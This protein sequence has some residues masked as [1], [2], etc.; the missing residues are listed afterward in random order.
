MTSIKLW[1]LGLFLLLGGC[2]ATAPSLQPALRADRLQGLRAA[3]EET[4]GETRII[5]QATQW[6][7]DAQVTPMKVTVIHSGGDPLRIAYDDFALQGASRNYA[8][9]APSQI[10]DSAWE[11]YEELS[12]QDMLV[13][14]MPEG[15]VKPGS[16]ISGYLYFERIDDE[17]LDVQ[18]RAHLE[19]ADSG[20]EVVNVS[21]PF[22]V[23]D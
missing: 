1:R 4:D 15:V 16:S 13:W 9:L 3:A 22:M 11:G 19:A 6:P 2:S 17:E 5:V 20:M 8:A 23:I 7:G 14:A 21:I 12:M 10:D 18:F